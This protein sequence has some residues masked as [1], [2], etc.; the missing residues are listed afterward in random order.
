MSSDS[1]QRALDHHLARLEQTEF[2]LAKRLLV[3]Y[4]DC[5]R[6]CETWNSWLVYNGTRWCKSNQEIKQLARLTIEALRHEALTIAKEEEVVLPDEPI[7]YEPL[8]L[9]NPVENP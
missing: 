4:G 7:H 6:Y 2:G 1:K 5:C 3:R 8:F 9:S